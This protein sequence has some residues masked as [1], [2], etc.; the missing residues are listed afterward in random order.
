LD[1]S[2]TFNEERSFGS[3]QAY[4]SIVL[5]DTF[6]LREG[7]AGTWLIEDEGKN[8]T[9]QFENMILYLDG[10]KICDGELIGSVSDQMLLDYIPRDKEV[11]KLKYELV[12]YE[13]D[14]CRMVNGEVQPVN[15]TDSTIE[16]TIKIDQSEKPM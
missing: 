2:E 7:N 5:P 14:R 4:L 8:R 3:K 15:Q 6:Q 12:L 9:N 16:F 1:L 10:I 13:D 11:A